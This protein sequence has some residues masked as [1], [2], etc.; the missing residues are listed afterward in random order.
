MLLPLFVL[1]N[2]V[3]AIEEGK[4]EKQKKT[5]CDMNSEVSRGSLRARLVARKKGQI[6][7]VSFAYASFLW[8]MLP[9]TMRV[10]H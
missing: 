1:R 4:K 10:L 9:M 6:R 7:Y 3:A 5:S 2:P 8:A